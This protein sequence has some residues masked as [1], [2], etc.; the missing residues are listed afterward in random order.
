MSVIP[1][2]RQLG[3]AKWATHAFKEGWIMEFISHACS[4]ITSSISQAKPLE[5]SPPLL[6]QVYQNLCNEKGQYL[7]K[8]YGG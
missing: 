4:I 5:P 2:N 6:K 7:P 1:G 3:A 8:F